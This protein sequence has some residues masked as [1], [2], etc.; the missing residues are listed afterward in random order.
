MNMIKNI[1]LS[2]TKVAI[3]VLLVSSVAC[4][5][6]S[7]FGGPE[8]VKASDN[9]AITSVFAVNDSFPDFD[10]IPELVYTAKFN[11]RVSWVVDI[12]G[13]QSGAV[14]NFTGV[15]ESI[16][17]VVWKGGSSNINF[18]GKDEPVVA[19][20]SVLGLSTVYSLY[21]TIR[22]AK[23]YHSFFIDTTGTINSVINGVKHILI[24]NFDDEE[25]PNMYSTI[26]NA[27]APDGADS[28]IKYGFSTDQKVQGASSYFMSGTDDN[29]NGWSGGSNSETL[30]EFYL[31][32]TVPALL[33]DSGVPAEDL[34]FN[35]FIY[36]TGLAS[37]TV[38]LKV[39]E[40]DEETYEKDTMIVL[41][42]R[43][44]LRH[45]LYKGD[46][47]PSDIVYDQ[48]KNDG[49]IYDIQVNW[50]GWKLV[51]IPYSLFRPNNDP[52]AGGA[53]NRNKESWRICGMA[54]SLL[55]FPT[56]GQHTE[57]YID[58]LTVTIGGPFQR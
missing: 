41:D 19:E 5:K 27:Y 47:L 48:S 36:G 32:D 28:D 44:A 29:N 2:S 57:V 10:S 8:V 39:Y 46:G 15:G 43:E 13:S 58:Y 30:L 18:F 7:D 1:L 49:F 23:S 42:S 56:T 53:G 6:K 22:G 25:M 17:G 20:L 38:Q 24:D 50:L 31:V 21:D 55:S 16:T 12:K 40:Y 9:F 26:S 52:S 14:K 3:A 45:A 37:T 34:Y 4:K 51:S 54:F 33:I 35:V 11:E